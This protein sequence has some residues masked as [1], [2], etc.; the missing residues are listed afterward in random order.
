M[1][2]SFVWPLVDYFEVA[3]MKKAFQL[4]VIGRQAWDRSN[5]NVDVLVQFPDST[6]YAATFFTLENIKSLIES[7]KES[8]ECD[9]GLYFWCAEMIIVEELSLEVMERTVESLLRE[10]EFSKVFQRCDPL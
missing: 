2:Y 6:A 4:D 10:D 1:K 8:G 5:D 7:Y 9:S 3:E